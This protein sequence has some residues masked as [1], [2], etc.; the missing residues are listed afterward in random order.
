MEREIEMD[1]KYE[2]TNETIVVNGHTLHRIKALRDF[3]NVKEGELG[4]FI[5]SEKNLSQDGLCWV[6]DEAKVYDDAKVYGNA[7]VYGH[8]RVYGY[9]EVYGNANV[10]GNAEVCDDV[11]VYGDAIV[12]GNAEVSGYAEVFGNALL[13]DEAKV[14]G[15]AKVHG[16]AV[17]RGDGKVYGD[18]R[19]YHDAQ[20][21]ANA[22]VYGNAKVSGDA[23][24][25][26]YAE[27]GKC[28]HIASPNDY[29]TI[30]PL[31]SRDGHTTVYRILN[32]DKQPCSSDLRIQCGCFN[33]TP[34]EFFAKV[35]ETYKEGSIYHTQYTTI[36]KPIVDA[37]CQTSIQNITD[38]G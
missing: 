34:D 20:V 17:I 5:E 6:F 27:I 25:F 15:Y 28:A 32:A 23:K 4:G 3:G 9:V 26:G 21:N 29:I 16:N 36:M 35:N 18:A 2:L 31:G 8:A 30:G 13:F 19:V 1:K 33:G 24:V 12:H 22:K 11:E 10:Y 38:K 37:M 14:Y 7:K